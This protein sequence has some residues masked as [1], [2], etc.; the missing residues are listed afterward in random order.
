MALPIAY[1]SG[2]KWKGFM[3]AT[4]SGVSEPIGALLVGGLAGWFGWLV[5]MTQ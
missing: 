5:A 4:L 1:A 2:S 3:W